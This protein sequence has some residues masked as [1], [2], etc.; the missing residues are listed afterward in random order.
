[1]LV[2]DRHR[3]VCDICGASALGETPEFPPPGWSILKARPA[4]GV[5]FVVHLCL[6][7]CLSVGAARLGDGRTIDGGEIAR[8]EIDS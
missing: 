2:E 3:F 4:R 6:V 8:K 7:P 1:M 5:G